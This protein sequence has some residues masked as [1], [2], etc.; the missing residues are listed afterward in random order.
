MPTLDDDVAGADVPADA[1]GG[2]RSSPR[3][4]RH[5]LDWKRQ[6]RERAHAHV[7]ATTAAGTRA[8]RAH[9]ERAR[10]RA[11]HLDVD[12]DVAGADVAADADGGL[13]LS[14]WRGRQPLD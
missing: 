2:L 5:P 13:K 3:R 6:K 4:G 7:R 8:A 1:D 11:R 9:G 10:E 14:P 12:A